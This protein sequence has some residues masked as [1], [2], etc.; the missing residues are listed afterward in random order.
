MNKKIH[1]SVVEAATRIENKIWLSCME[2]NGL[3]CF[4]LEKEK[5]ELKHRFNVVG[6]SKYDLHRKVVC[7]EN[8]LYLFPRSDDC[9]RIYDMCNNTEDVIA[10]PVK[11]NKLWDVILL[12]TQAIIYLPKGNTFFLFNLITKKFEDD[13]LILEKIKLILSENNTECLMEV[14]NN[15]IFVLDSDK[16][17]HVISNDNIDTIDLNLIKEKIV[18]MRFKYNHLWI[19]VADGKDVIYSI[20]LENKQID[21]Y[22]G[23]DEKRNNANIIYA[24]V[25]K[26]DGTLYALNWQGNDIRIIDLVNKIITN[27]DIKISYP[28]CMSE[29][30]YWGYYEEYEGKHYIFPIA[31][32][33]ILVIEK[34][35]YREIESSIMLD[36]LEDSDNIIKEINKKIKIE[37]NFF[38][39]DSFINSYI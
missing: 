11:Q 35:N 24:D 5:Y 8:K 13:N 16:Y 22:I 15:D 23:D 21:K 28:R 34:G 31:G 29:G 32:R 10:I 17:L 7:L 27:S 3:L 2:Y 18:T 37:N 19:F 26:I 9:I 4:D 1:V 20:D 6:G 33:N 12:G 14:N 36:E 39:V 38:G 25:C 30:R